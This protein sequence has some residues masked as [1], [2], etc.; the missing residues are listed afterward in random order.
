MAEQIK[1]LF[2]VKTPGGPWNIVLDVVP[3]PPQRKKNGPTFKFWDP[4]VSPE[5]LKL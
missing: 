1:I 5:W 4:L 3:D 2:G